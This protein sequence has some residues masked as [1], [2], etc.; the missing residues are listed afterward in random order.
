MEEAVVGEL[1]EPKA[2]TERRL[3]QIAVQPA[4]GVQLGFLHHIRGIQPGTEPAVGPQPDEA[5]QKRPVPGKEPLFG[6]RFARPDFLEQLERVRRVGCDGVHIVLW[7][8]NS[9][10]TAE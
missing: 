6:S 5:T 10:I 4:E 9:Q 2:K 7:S 1:A 3:R 8:S